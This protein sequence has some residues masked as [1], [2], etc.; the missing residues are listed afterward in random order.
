MCIVINRFGKCI[1]VMQSLQ[2][3]IQDANFRGNQ[4]LILF[5]QMNSLNI[6]NYSTNDYPIGG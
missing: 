1:A 2:I 6:R 4:N 5:M 3:N